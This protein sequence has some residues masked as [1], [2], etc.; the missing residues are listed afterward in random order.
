[1]RW[2]F[3]SPRK[4][5]E[6]MRFHSYHSWRRAEREAL[7]KSV[8]DWAVKTFGPRRAWKREAARRV[9]E[10]ACELAQA[11]GVPDWEAASI[12]RH[13]YDKPTGLI[14]DEI[15]DVQLTLFAF[16]GSL[17]ISVADV[18]DTRFRLCLTR[19]VEFYRAKHDKKI[20]AGLSEP[21]VWVD[22][23]SPGACKCQFNIDGE[24]HLYPAPE[25]TVEK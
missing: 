8:L 2:I 23:S 17:G 24:L 19:P 1:M 18:A 9:F 4:A 20:A 22:C 13:V 10:E 5:W 21:R 25:C 11:A 12:Q 14:S 16:A 3:Q 15:A 6:N 7:Q